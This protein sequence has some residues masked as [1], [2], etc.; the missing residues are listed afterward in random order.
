[1]GS[2][3]FLGYKFYCWHLPPKKYIKL[4]INSFVI[5]IQEYI[6][7]LQTD[8]VHCLYFLNFNFLKRAKSQVAN[9][10]CVYVHTYM[11]A[12]TFVC[13]NY[14]I[15]VIKIWLHFIHITVLIKIKDNHC[16]LFTY[17]VKSNLRRSLWQTGAIENIWTVYLNWE[18]LNYTFIVFWFQYWYAILKT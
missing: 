6:I 18:S 13:V 10:F 5:K 3:I 9:L 2:S 16:I 4:T 14:K 11:C 7:L 1:M 17:W 12:Y 8:S 15:C